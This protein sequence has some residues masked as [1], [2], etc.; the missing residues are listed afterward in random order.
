MSSRSRRSAGTGEW[1]ALDGHTPADDGWSSVAYNH[2]LRRHERTP[3]GTP[4][5]VHRRRGAAGRS[6]IGRARRR[7]QRLIDL[8]L[9]LVLALLAIVLA[10]GLAIVA[11]L[12]LVGLLACGASFAVGR[13]RRRRAGR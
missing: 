13:A 6:P 2:S 9:G 8:A 10:P 1:E 7:R 5:R 3:R 11:L 4:E 12:A